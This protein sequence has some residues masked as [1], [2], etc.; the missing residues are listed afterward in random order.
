MY[1]YKN[2]I[3]RI[4]VTMGITVKGR[5]PVSPLL[6]NTQDHCGI[7]KGG[8]CGTMRSHGQG[9]PRCPS[10]MSALRL[11]LVA[12]RELDGRERT[13]K[14]PSIDWL[15]YWSMGEGEASFEDF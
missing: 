6:Y 9:V 2:S 15:T 3:F 10:A 14:M 1:R 5:E 4:Q 8:K 12:W 13:G 7:F 11:P